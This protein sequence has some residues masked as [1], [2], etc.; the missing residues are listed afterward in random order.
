MKIRQM[1]LLESYKNFFQIDVH[2]IVFLLYFDSTQIRISF[3]IFLG[4]FDSVCHL[5]KLK[6]VAFY[7]FCY[8]DVIT[9]GFLGP[10][11]NIHF[12]MKKL[13]PCV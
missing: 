4:I 13:C 11:Q 10:S 9:L 1:L 12:R 6:L 3:V 7:R 8:K 5:G 2:V